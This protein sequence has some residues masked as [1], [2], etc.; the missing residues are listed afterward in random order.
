MRIQLKMSGTLNFVII[1]INICSPVFIRDSGYN[2]CF[3]F[4]IDFVADSNYFGEL[5]QSGC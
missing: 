4:L 1:I 5:C 2:V 3:A